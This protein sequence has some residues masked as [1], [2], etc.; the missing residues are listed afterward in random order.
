MRR[1]VVVGVILMTFILSACTGSSEPEQSA[2]SDTEVSATPQPHVVEENEIVPGFPVG[3]WTVAGPSSHRSSSL[4]TRMVLV[5]TVRWSGIQSMEWDIRLDCKETTRWSMSAG[6]TA[7][8][9]WMP[10]RTIRLVSEDAT[11]TTFRSYL[12]AVPVGWL[13]LGCERLRRRLHH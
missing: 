3:V 7:V 8:S 4:P 12:T 5:A 13:M 2:N 1:I 9:H 10:T 6:T 11:G